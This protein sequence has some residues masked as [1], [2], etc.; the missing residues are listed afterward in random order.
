MGFRLRIPI[1]R[2]SLLDLSLRRIPGLREGIVEPSPVQ[3]SLCHAVL[4]FWC[5][6]G[7]GVGRGTTARNWCAH[8]CRLW[9][10]WPGGDQGPWCLAAHLPARTR[11]GASRIPT[12][13]PSP[14]TSPL[15][16]ANYPD[17]RALSTSGSRGGSPLLRTWRAVARAW[18]TGAPPFQLWAGSARP[19]WRVPLGHQ[20][21]C[22]T[23]SLTASPHSPG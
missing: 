1:C 21:L 9:N 15:V 19:A 13:T 11:T 7:A 22:P 8:N 14:T 3:T 20:G 2:P 4:N 17:P 5:S 10:R 18:L 12:R 6:S 16:R 23:L